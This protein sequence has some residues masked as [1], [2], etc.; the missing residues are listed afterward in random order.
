MPAAELKPRKGRLTTQNPTIVAR[1]LWQPSHCA[2]GTL[3]RARPRDGCGDGGAVLGH[4]SVDDADGEAVLLR[5]PDVTHERVEHGHDDMLL[6]RGAVVE[7]NLL[8]A[9]SR[10]CGVGDVRR[11]AQ[12]SAACHCE[13]AHLC[14]ITREFTWRYSPSRRCSLTVKR[15]T[16]RRSQFRNVPL[17][18]RY[19]E[20][21][22]GGRGGGSCEEAGAEW[23]HVR[24]CVSHPSMFPGPCMPMVVLSLY[25]YSAMSR[26]GLDR[27][28][29]RL[30]TL[31]QNRATSCRSTING[32]RHS[33][34]GDGVSHLTPQRHAPPTWVSSWSALAMRLSM[35]L[36]CH[37]V[38][39]RQQQP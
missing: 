32:A 18:I 15:P 6:V 3:H 39:A 7:G 28:E 1:Y 17:I 37:G 35:L 27:F 2:N 5:A 33:Q 13:Q 11:P 25:V 19:L 22:D 26:I 4:E 10:A 12:H 38:V 21:G 9:W 20:Q 23:R 16:G 24:Q 34:R 8:A 29:Y 14:W 30:V 31:S 36:T